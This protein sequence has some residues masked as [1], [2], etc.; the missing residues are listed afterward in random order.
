VS[1]LVGIPNEPCLFFADILENGPRRGMGAGVPV[2]PTSSPTGCR[3]AVAGD[4]TI[5][6]DARP[7]V[8]R[9]IV[10]SRPVQLEPVVAPTSHPERP[11]APRRN[12]R[13]R[14]AG[15]VGFITSASAAF[16]LV[17]APWNDDTWRPTGPPTASEGVP[18]EAAKP[19]GGFIDSIDF[20]SEPVRPD[21]FFR[22]AHIMVDGR[23]YT[24]VARRLDAGC[25]DRSGAGAA[26]LAGDRCRQLIRAVYASDYPDRAEPAAARVFAS[27]AVAVADNQVTA[28]QAAA[29]ADTIT[30]RPPRGSRGRD[31]RHDRHRASIKENSLVTNK[32]SIPRAII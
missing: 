4:R 17:V 29:N 24:R 18:G 9:L 27:V 3:T 21:E 23:T 11:G 8:A 13:R 28:A 7:A 32:A 22:D 16:T 14:L 30:V 20:D 6:D 10:A 31:D 1:D 15:L 19:W 2:S 25:P 12:R 26:I 5:G